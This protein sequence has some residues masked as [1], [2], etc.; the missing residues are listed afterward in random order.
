MEKALQSCSITIF[1]VPCACAAGTTTRATTAEQIAGMPHRTTRQ[2][3]RENGARR[4][5]DPRAR[6]CA[7]SVLIG[8]GRLLPDSADFFKPLPQ[9]SFKSPI[10]GS[11]VGPA[12]EALGKARHIRDFLR[13]VVS[14]LIAFAVADVPHQSRHRISKMQRD[15]LR[16]GSLQILLGMSVAS[17]KSV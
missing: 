16:D 5:A 8:F 14:I 2:R 11:V 17:V 9:A 7:A 10:C 15:R 1:G 12:G 6:N 13:R 4:G 3:R